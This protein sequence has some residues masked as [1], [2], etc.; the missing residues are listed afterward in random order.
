MRQPKLRDYQKDQKSDIYTRI[1]AGDKRIVAQLS[2]GGGKTILFSSIASDCVSKGKRTLV[3]AH[4]KE[5]IVQAAQKTEWFTGCKP[6]II[7]AGYPMHKD[8]PIQVGSIQT[9]H[10]RKD[11]YPAGFFDFS[12]IVID[13]CHRSIARTYGEI[14]AMCD[15]PIVLGVTAT[16]IRSDNKGLGDLYES[17]VCGIGTQ[18]LIDT[19]A[20]CPYK[21]LAQP[22]ETSDA[23]HPINAVIAYQKYADG[24][25]NIVFAQ[26]VQH[27]I[28]IAQAF[29]DAGIKTKHLDGTTPDKVR[30]NT[31]D[32]FSSKNI[33]VLVNCG[34][35]IEGLDV[36]GIEVVQIMKPMK[37]IASYLQ[38]LGRGLRP[39]PGKD[40]A[41]FLDHTT[42]HIDHGHPAD[43]RVWSLDGLIKRE[44]KTRVI[45]IDPEESIFNSEINLI[46]VVGDRSA[47][48]QYHV[49]FARLIDLAK[50]IDKM[51]YQIYDQI[52]KLRP[53]LDIWYKY[54][55]ICGESSSWAE[56]VH[57]GIQTKTLHK[58]RPP[59]TKPLHK[60]PKQFSRYR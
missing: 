6:G 36:P 19:N 32:K 48:E 59:R 8:R 18:D 22:A 11:K 44:K 43:V 34:L 16:P 41:L 53:P 4:R 17:M 1:K 5:L 56:Q 7:K 3:L 37:S 24:L 14:L 27:S 40:Y 33:Q 39:A 29:N 20:L 52:I 31:I 47:T 46:D 12:L 38:V 25:Q 2:T 51:P 45:E 42:G 55:N 21:I 50:K 57:L 60:K 49:E 28:D 15:N 10:S 26:D 58:I 13:E 30:S 35:F 9:L 23:L 54:A